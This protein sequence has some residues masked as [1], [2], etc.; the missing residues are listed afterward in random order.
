M[1]S[2][3]RL[4]GRSALNRWWLPRD[5][6]LDMIKERVRKYADLFDNSNFRWLFSA[7]I[8]SVVGDN[9]YL[10]ASMWLVYVLTGSTL[11]TGVAAFLGSAPRTL[12]FLAGPIVDRHNP[13]NMLVGTELAQMTIVLLVP[14]SALFGRLN[15]WVVLAII[16][17]LAIS[18]QFARPAQNTALPRIVDDDRLVNANSLLLLMNRGLQAFSKAIAGI[19]I[20]LVG[21]VALYG[22]NAVTFFLGAAAFSMLHVPP[23]SS[24][25]T[26]HDGD[27]PSRRERVRQYV[28]ELK[29]GGSVTVR[30]AVLYVVASTALANFLTG[31]STAVLPAFASEAG[32]AAAYGILYGGAG[33]GLFAG[34]AIASFVEEYPLGLVS[35]ASFSVVSFSWILAVL[36]P[37]FSVT[38]LLFTV[39]WIP[40]GIY[41][42]LAVTALQTGVPD[43]LLG[44]VMSVDNSVSGSLSA[45][46]LL[47]G[48]FAGE[49][50]PSAQ[51]MIIAGVG[52]L[53]VSLY[54]A[55]IPAARSF[56]P[57]SEIDA[58]EFQL[59]IAE[60]ELSDVAHT[61]EK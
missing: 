28:S 61:G 6:D 43:E 1:P 19:L 10:V 46:A 18:N 34:A 22:L 27:Q 57:I 39:A 48:G 24:E 41:N 42:V 47:I 8:I 13:R 25:T 12:G 36:V 32:G 16:P 21:A 40:I 14:L 7:R 30:S 37:I 35:I 9:L 26:A 60:S 3:E 17:L 38:V 54:W 15:I 55:L 56:A 33:A 51:V 58:D 31:I 20:S 53:A 44:R 23:R 49:F 59:P 45:A 11:Y 2:G 52:F 50:L 5:V 4:R 29:R